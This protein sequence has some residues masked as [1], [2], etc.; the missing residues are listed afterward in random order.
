MDELIRHPLAYARWLHGWSQTE[1]ARRVKEAARRR[2]RRAGTSRQRVSLWE[3]SVTPDEFSQDLLADVFDVP[4]DRVTA[5][6]WPHWLPGQETPAPLGTGLTVTVLRKAAQMAVDR[7]TFLTY[8]PAALSALA[9]QWATIDPALAA[10]ATNGRPVDPTFVDW[11][12]KAARDLNSLPTAHRQHTGALLDGHLTTVVDLLEHGSYSSNLETRLHALAAGLSQTIGWHRFDH[13]HHAAANRHWHAAVHAA[14]QAG[15]TDMG[16]G[17]LSDIAYQ[18]IWLGQPRA[19]AEGL[20][21]ALSR[22]TNPTARS[23]LFLRKARAH[24]MLQESRACYRDLAQ[25]EKSLNS[26][27]DA[28]PRWCSWMSPADLA[29]DSGRCLAELGNTKQAH[30]LITEG[31]AVLPPARNK[32]RAVFLTYEAENY[33]RAGDPEQAAAAAATSLSLA[34]RINAPRCIAMVRDLEPQFAP[35]ARTANVSDLLDT[36]RAAS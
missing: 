4:H 26:A 24:A 15:D 35:H 25:A 7:R 5:L 3:T 19:A 29:V 2:D 33:L 30:R 14:H 13:E 12:E 28:A 32:T 22:T 6:G 36:L 31:I 9:L 34:H 21:H 1:L 10:G 11:L 8:T 18:N 23:L 16:A 17:A 27:T 20:E